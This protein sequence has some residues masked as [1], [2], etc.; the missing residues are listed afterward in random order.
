MEP[1]ERNLVSD[2]KETLR[3]INIVQLAPWLAGATANN[4]GFLLKPN[5]LRMLYLLVLWDYISNHH[6]VN[7]PTGK[8]P[9]IENDE[10]IT[11]PEADLV[12]MVQLIFHE[13]YYPC[14]NRVYNM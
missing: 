7:N 13:D 6:N 12:R 8:V 11:I 4:N 3:N 9:P 10:Q 14:F 2:S 5:D 1:K